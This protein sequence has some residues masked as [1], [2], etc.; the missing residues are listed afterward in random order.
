MPETVKEAVL[1]LPL[2]IRSLTFTV[3]RS[4]TREMRT[5]VVG[6]S[7]FQRFKTD[8]RPLYV[9]LKTAVSY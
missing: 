2:Y 3:E 9:C 6:T 8:L 4:N 5:G 7:G 1:D